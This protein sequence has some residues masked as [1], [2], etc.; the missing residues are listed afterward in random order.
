MN[1][2]KKREIKEY[3]IGKSHGEK[4]KSG[5]YKYMNIIIKKQKT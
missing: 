2:C 5:R 1:I 4:Y 3:K